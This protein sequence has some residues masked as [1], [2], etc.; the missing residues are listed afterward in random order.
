MV[1]EGSAHRR[2]AVS[3]QGKTEK[4]ENLPERG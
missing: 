3:G 4:L 1:L 2:E